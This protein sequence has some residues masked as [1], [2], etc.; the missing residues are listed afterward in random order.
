MTLPSS[1]PLGPAP[2]NTKVCRPQKKARILVVNRKWFSFSLQELKTI[3]CYLTKHQHST[4]SYPHPAKSIF[5]NFCAKDNL[6]TRQEDPVY[7]GALPLT[8][9]KRH[10]KSHGWLDL[11]KFLSNLEVGG[12]G[13]RACWFQSNRVPSSQG[14]GGETQI[15]VL[16]R[17][18]NSASTWICCW[19]PNVTY[20]NTW[21]SCR[22]GAGPQKNQ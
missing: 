12:A 18:L 15:P 17:T 11:V 2:G 8:F 16:D 20:E 7:V 4:F 19:A 22:D 10:P 13:R 6:A 5:K 21:P 1:H 14:T 9:P 3:F